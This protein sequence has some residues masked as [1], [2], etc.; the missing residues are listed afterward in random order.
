MS[1]STGRWR[2]AI[3]SLFRLALQI[4]TFMTDK[5]IQ[6]NKSVKAHGCA[7]D[8]HCE[9]SKLNICSGVWAP[10]FP[11]WDGKLTQAGLTGPGS[12]VR[13]RPRRGDAQRGCFPFT[14]WYLGELP[15]EVTSGQAFTRVGYPLWCVGKPVIVSMDSRRT[16]NSDCSL[17]SPGLLNI[18]WGVPGMF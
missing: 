4:C 7:R 2:Y 6:C 17:G 1:Y 18:D 12:W 10:A 9:T 16:Q 3:Y 13:S 5:Q 14:C 15:S 8:S 11:H